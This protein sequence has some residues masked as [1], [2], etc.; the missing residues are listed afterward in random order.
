M[1]MGVASGE[2]TVQDS[3][4]LSQKRP[5]RHYP[6]PLPKF[7]GNDGLGLGN[8]CEVFL[9]RR[10]KSKKSLAFTVPQ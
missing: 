7:W 2:E 5:G 9:E 1:R 8:L 6:R 10:V 4:V 3:P